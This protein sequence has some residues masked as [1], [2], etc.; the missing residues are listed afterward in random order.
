MDKNKKFKLP[1]LFRPRSYRQTQKLLW[2]LVAVMTVVLFALLAYLLMM[3]LQPPEVTLGGRPVGEVAGDPAASLPYPTDQDG[4]ELRMLDHLIPWY[5]ENNALVGWLRID[6]TRIDYPVIHTPEDED[7][8]LRKNFNGKFSMEGTLLVGAVCSTMPESDNIIIYGHNMRSGTM[9]HDLMN[10]KKESYW[11]E[12]PIIEYS[13]L[14]EERQYEIIAAFYDR[15]YGKNEKVFK[16][17]QFANYET[18]DEF[19]DAMVY[20]QSKSEYDTGVVPVYGD[21]L[22][23]LVTCSYHESK[24]RFVVVAREITDEVLPEA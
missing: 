20:F 2:N 13:T 9:F 17:Y 19:W 10:Y 5:Q 18:E 8:Y 22:L 23:T 16:F 24:G 3:F 21:R 1:G 4:T 14:F 7:L 15:I 12:H 11:E 6:G